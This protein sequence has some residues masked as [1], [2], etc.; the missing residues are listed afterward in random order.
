MIIIL[1]LFA[2]SSVLSDIFYDLVFDHYI[3]T[4]CSE[5]CVDHYIAT[6]CSVLSDIFYDLVFDHYIATF[7]PKM[8]FLKELLK[9]F[10]LKK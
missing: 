4:I 8:L 2:L 3:A 1:P 6:V 5:L 10:V 9:T 7:L